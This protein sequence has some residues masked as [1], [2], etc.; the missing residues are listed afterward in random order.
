MRTPP[1]TSARLTRSSRNTNPSS[2]AASGSVEATID[3]HKGPSGVPG[4]ELEAA[5]LVARYTDAGL[6]VD[7]TIG[8]SHA[9]GKIKGTITAAWNGADWDFTGSAKVDG[10]VD[11]R[12]GDP[13]RRTGRPTH[14]PR[15]ARIPWR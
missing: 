15:D 8:L 1:A 4:I 10:L 9:S 5:H 2:A 3:V 7:G 6:K 11:G 14:E 12:L 13:P